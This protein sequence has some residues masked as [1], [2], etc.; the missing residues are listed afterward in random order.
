MSLSEKYPE[1]ARLGAELDVSA[2]QF[3]FLREPFKFTTAQDARKEEIERAKRL[4]DILK[5]CEIHFVEDLVR[6]GQANVRTL[7][8][9]EIFPHICLFLEQNNIPWNIQIRDEQ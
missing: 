2:E 9:A 5:K 1:L 4:N 8:G 3:H 7:V 6:M